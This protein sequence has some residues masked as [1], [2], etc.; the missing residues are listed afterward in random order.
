MR[1]LALRARCPNGARKRHLLR[2]IYNGADR[3]VEPRS[4]GYASD[5][6]EVVVVYQ[7]GGESAWG[8]DEGW[9]AL[10][11]S[12]IEELQVVAVHSSLTDPAIVEVHPR[13]SSKSIAPS[14]RVQSDEAMR[15]HRL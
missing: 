11:V 7:R 4:H 13:T 9:K 15:R 14:D 5:G 3:L 12:Q 1:N 6:H 2:L 10:V 8:Q